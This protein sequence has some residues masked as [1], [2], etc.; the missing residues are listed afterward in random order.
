MSGRADVG[1]WNKSEDEVAPLNSIIEGLSAVQADVKNDLDLQYILSFEEIHVL[2][3][4]R[5]KEYPRKM[6]FV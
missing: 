5:G 4:F 6:S 1:W 2:C 3:T